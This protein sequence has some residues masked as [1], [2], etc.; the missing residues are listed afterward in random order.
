[1]Q[2]LVNGLL[3]WAVSLSSYPEAAKLPEL[4]AIPH[5]Q[6]EATLCNHEQCNAVAYYD[7]HADIVYYDQNLDLENSLIAKSFI[8]HELVHYLQDQSGKMKHFPLSCEAHI[9]LE[10]EAY[11]VQ[12]RYLSEH[13][14]VT[15][16]IDMA[17]HL[18]GGICDSAPETE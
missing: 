1:M 4:I 9:S 15:H 14:T 3:M 13:Q 12:Q 7:H 11:Q 18:L 6:L 16:H 17:I 8:V 5:A 10:R 2:Q